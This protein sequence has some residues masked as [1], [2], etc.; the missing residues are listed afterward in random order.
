MGETALIA[1]IPKMSPKINVRMPA[2]FKVVLLPGSIYWAFQNLRGQ[3]WS[4]GSWGS[5]LFDTPSLA[6]D[7][8]WT[9]TLL[10]NQ[11]PI[12]PNPVVRFSRSS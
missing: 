8:M 5:R 6:A 11:V 2:A 1:Q 9:R 4:W 7:S 10:G 12:A 3:S